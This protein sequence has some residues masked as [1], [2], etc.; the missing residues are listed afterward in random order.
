MVLVAK[1]YPYASRDYV[2]HE[3][4]L[5]GVEVYRA[6]RHK[7]V[8]QHATEILSKLNAAAD[9][10]SR[11]ILIIEDGGYFTPI[12]HDIEFANVAMRC[13]GVVEQTTK[14][15]RQDERSIQTFKV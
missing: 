3:L 5:L 13:I 10:Q 7:G 14:G 6:S 1:P 9:L 11:K 15:I 8:S 2:T 4:E 12:L